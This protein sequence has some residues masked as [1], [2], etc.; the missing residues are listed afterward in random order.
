MRKLLRI[1]AVDKL[2]IYDL[3]KYD[4]QTNA[5]K[6]EVCAKPDAVLVQVLHRHTHMRSSM[7]TK[8]VRILRAIK[9]WAV[10]W[11]LTGRWS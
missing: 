6:L 10:N 8:I 7:M 4:W 9:Q 5:N 3:N 11:W 1:R 2:Y